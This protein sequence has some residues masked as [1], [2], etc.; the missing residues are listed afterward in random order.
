MEVW[1][2]L[3]NK[4]PVAVPSIVAREALF[5]YQEP[6]QVS[7]PIDLPSLIQEGKVLEVTA[8]GSELDALSQ[9]FDRVFLEGLHDGEK[10]ALA[11]LHSR[12]YPLEICSGDKIAIHALAMM[13]RGADGVSFEAVLRRIGLSKNVKGEFT[14]EYFKRHL[15]VGYQKRITGEG[16]RR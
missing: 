16:L 8:T 11:L 15:G 13:D 3:L 7:M 10:E 4:R 14:E 9:I 5:Y 6:H 2:T 12:Q 1:E